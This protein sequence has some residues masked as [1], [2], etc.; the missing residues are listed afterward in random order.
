MQTIKACKGI[1][2]RASRDFAQEL[3][4]L[5]DKNL[6]LAIWKVRRDT[7]KDQIERLRQAP[8]DFRRVQNLILDRARIQLLLRHT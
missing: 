6:S 7:F 2:R 1:E 8:T 3:V 5:N 4:T